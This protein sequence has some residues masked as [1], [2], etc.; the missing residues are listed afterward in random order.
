MAD[1]KG[2]FRS[3]GNIVFNAQSISERTDSLRVS[4]D[5]III[6][7]EGLAATSS[8]KFLDNT[9]PTPLEASISWNGTALTTS[10]PISGAVT[11]TDAGGDGSLGITGS[12]ITYNGP[13]AAEVRA[14]FS[15]CLLYTSD[16]ADE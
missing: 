2:I 9:S 15:G 10:T 3:P 7:S 11:V 8:L 12:T 6:N 5:N 16:A 4:D 13:T 14:H 1:K